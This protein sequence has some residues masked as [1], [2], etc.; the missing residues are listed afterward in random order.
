MPS[1]ADLTV[2]TGNDREV[3]RGQ[4][5]RIHGGSH[6]PRA[7]RLPGTGLGVGGI[8]EQKMFDH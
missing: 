4:L 2:G 6:Y 7:Q 5:D 8:T 1:A 3:R